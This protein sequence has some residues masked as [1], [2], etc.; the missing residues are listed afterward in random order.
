M[1]EEQKGSLREI[2]IVANDKTNSELVIEREYNA[3]TYFIDRHLEEGRGSKV[4]FIDSKGETSYGELS[5]QVNK[6]ANL[7]SSLGKNSPD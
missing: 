6:A 4:A 7:F 3:A 1:P 2:K 5:A